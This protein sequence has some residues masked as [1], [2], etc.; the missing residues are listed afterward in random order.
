MGQLNLETKTA[1]GNSGVSIVEAGGVLDVNTVGD[2][3]AALEGLFRAKRYKIVLDLAKLDYI[4]SSGIG[5]LIGNIKEIRRNKGDIRISSVKPEVFKV[6]SILELPRIFY[7]HPT[8][9]EAVG[10]F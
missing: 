1:M 2:F 6:F 5:V 8:E 4:S 7:F 10:A 3:E 9:Q